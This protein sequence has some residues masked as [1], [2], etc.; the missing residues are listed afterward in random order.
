MKKIIVLSA[1]LYSLHGFA[2]TPNTTPTTTKNPQPTITAN[3]PVPLNSY[4]A[5]DVNANVPVAAQVPPKPADFK[6]TPFTTL[7]QQ[8]PQN[9][10]TPPALDAK[11]YTLMDAKTGAVLAA[12]RPNER[13][14]PASITKLMLLYIAEQEL[15][16]GQIHMDDIVTVP[17]VAWATG[18]SR[19]FLKP[20]D[21]IAIKD[22]IPG[23]IVDSGNDAA[24]TLATHIAGTQDAMVSLMNHQAQRLGMTNTH[25]SDV[26]GLPAPR[27][28]SSSYDLAKL[29]RAMV[30]QFP[31]YQ[32]WFSQKWYTYNGIRQPNFNKLLFMYPYAD[33]MK[34]GS[35]SAAGY[36]LVS[37]A[38]IP[39]RHMRL[40]AVVL[41]TPS[42]HLAAAESKA[43]LTY[44]FNFFTNKTLV[45]A[46]KPLD[47]VKTYFGQQK[48]TPIGL[49]K[50]LVATLPQSLGNKVNAT[51]KVGESIKAPLAKNQPIGQVEIKVDGKPLASVPAVALKD[52]PEGGFFSRMKDHLSL[53]F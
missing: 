44:G 32:A 29:A 53:W 14:A 37:T 46:Y 42:D 6:D 50:T 43:L 49:T 33:G 18:G 7:A 40:I 12:S 45:E 3:S 35:T 5:V 23:I 39:E 21:K 24:V 51:L 48:S 22:L 30:T 36:S 15:A 19:M 13:L 8:W 20:G 41:G 25:F 1:L 28:Y 4:G 17:Q 10:P 2:E 47:N 11:S 9:V 31:Q 26:M 27:H 16:K 34:T 52:N 38:K